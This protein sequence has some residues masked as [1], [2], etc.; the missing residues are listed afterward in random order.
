MHELDPKYLEQMEQIAQDIQESDELAQYLEEEEEE[1]YT[2]LKEMFE[3]RI[4]ALHE[5][6]ADETPLQ[7]VSFEVV[8]LDP[9]FEGLYLPKIL[10]YSVLRGEYNRDYKYVRPQEHFKDVLLAICNSANF[11]ILKKRIGQS[12]QMGVAFS[13]DIWVTNLINAIENKRVRYYLQSQKLDRFRMPEERAIGLA[14]YK[15]QF[16]NENYQ[17]AEFPVDISGLKVLFSQLKS[18]LIYRINRNG[19]NSSLIEPLKTFI[20]RKEFQGTEEHMQ[21]MVLF[22]GFFELEKEDKANL[23]TVFNKVRKDDPEFAQKYFRFL[24]ELHHNKTLDLSPSADQ[25]LSLIMDR[26]VK[27]QLSNFYDV[28]DTIHER[29]YVNDEVHQTIKLYYNQNKGVSLVNECIRQIIFH[30]FARNFKNM[31]A[32]AYP[33]FFEINKHFPVYM[34]IFANQKFNQNIKDLFMTYVKSLLKKYTDK[35]GKDYQDIKKFVS[36]AFVDFGF[37][38]EKEVIELFKTRRKRKKGE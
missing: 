19:N 18:F 10:G 2:R 36:T 4:A 8:M 17:S 3:P 21:T 23:I 13:S 37:L 28:V 7:L 33:E 27:D 31:D 24:L 35:R 6:V 9:A 30:Y 16:Q 29:G 25:R 15:R 22:G 26:S 11:D 38:T 32:S 5:Q 20:N 14:R 34:G 1:L 12:I